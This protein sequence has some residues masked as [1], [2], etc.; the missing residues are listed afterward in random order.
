[1]RGT[2]LLPT[3]LREI[4]DAKKLHFQFTLHKHLREIR[5]PLFLYTLNHELFCS[6]TGSSF[7]HW[8]LTCLFVFFVTRVIG[9]LNLAMRATGSFGT[10]FSLW[11][12]QSSTP[13]GSLFRWK[14]V[15]VAANPFSPIGSP[16]FGCPKSSCP[17]YNCTMGLLS[18]YLVPCCPGGC[19]GHHLSH[20][21]FDNSANFTWAL[22]GPFF[23]R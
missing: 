18:E 13:L 15:T 5:A 19:T 8:H 14:Q 1:V 20:Q 17:R 23:F 10:V 6:A 21:L 12:K 9:L 2:S 3:K 16:L 11:R 7:N 22:F 4:Y